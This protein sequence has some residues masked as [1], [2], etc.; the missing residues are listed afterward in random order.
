MV[1]LHI[2]HE[3]CCF[4]VIAWGVAVRPSLN[5]NYWLV[6]AAVW[7][8]PVLK[9]LQCCC[10][11]LFLTI[12]TSD[13]LLPEEEI[14]SKTK[15]GEWNWSREEQKLCL[16]MTSCGDTTSKCLLIFNNKLMFSSLS[17]YGLGPVLNVLHAQLNLIFIVALEMDRYY[18]HFTD[19]ETKTRRGLATWIYS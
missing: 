9:Y 4:R 16:S 1:C 14:V 11:A 7:D 17:V 10:S 8:W 12:W 18:A 19:E 15:Y 5:Q 13:P 6:N 2:K 3:P